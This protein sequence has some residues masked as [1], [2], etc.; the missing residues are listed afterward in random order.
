M[1]GRW[2]DVRDEPGTGRPFWKSPGILVA[3]A[4]LLL[5]FFIIAGIIITRDGGAE[6]LDDV[7][8]R[9]LRGDPDGYDGRTVELIGVVG[10]RYTIPVLDQYGLYEFNDGSGSMFVLSDK[11]VPPGGDQPVRLTAVFN[12]ATELDDQIRRLIEDQLGAAAGFVADQFL[13]SV[14]LNVLYLTHQRYELIEGA[15]TAP[16]NRYELPVVSG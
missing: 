9:Q 1:S 16:E 6:T 13:P 3:G 5:V 8:I 12:G 4:F 2:V 7:T 10:D 11:G 15:G 14:P